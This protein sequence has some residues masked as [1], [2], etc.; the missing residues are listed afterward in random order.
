MFPQEP[1]REP[2][3]TTGDGYAMAL[4]AGAV[5]T[6]MEFTQYMLHPIKPFPVRA[7]GMFWAL[8]PTVRNRHGK[9]A[10]APYLPPGVD[11]AQVMYERTLHY[12][13]SSRDA[14][15][16]LDIAIATEVR[17]GR[18]TEVGG[19]Y[20]DFSDVDIAGFKPAR[21]QHMPQD[22]ALPVELPDGWVQVRPAAHA[23]NGGILI[24]ERA[25]ATL[26]GLF[27]AGEVAAG[28]HG[29]DR[30]GGGMVTNCQVFGE[31]AG[32]SAGA[33]AL[34]TGTRGLTSEM[35]DDPL[36]RL[37]QFGRGSDDADDVL[38]ALQQTT[39][40]NLMVTRSE[41]R[42]THFLGTLETLKI[43][44]LPRI[45]VRHSALLK[46]AI[47]VENSLMTAELM[48]RAALMRKES[49]GN[50]YR[51]DYPEQDDDWQVILLKRDNDALIQEKGTL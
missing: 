30:L 45:A 4:R 49:R 15:G 39:G 21:P 16:W 36:A 7:P 26:P 6:N 28:P 51:E 20:L 24:D 40:E 47:E 43:E 18:G 31:R 48:A 25:S 35:L 38:F 27:A 12:P 22:N 44:R 3:D 32:R 41:Q 34:G 5:L 8:C 10:L 37:Q 11:A 14:S 42:L 50:H 29:A 1:D 2:I 19:L 33:Y 13:F 9:D 17:E 46:R 23:I